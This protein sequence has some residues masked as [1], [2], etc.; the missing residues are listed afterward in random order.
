ML[1]K[2]PKVDG[3]KMRHNSTEHALQAQCLAKVQYLKEQKGE[4]IWATKI[5]S[6]TR[7][8]CPDIILCIKGDFVGVELKRPGSPSRAEGKVSDLQLLNLQ[9]IQR[10]GGFSYVVKYFEDF[11]L[12][13][14]YHLNRPSLSEKETSYLASLSQFTL[15][16]NYA[17]RKAVE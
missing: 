16:N 5:T 3:Q 17:R 13:L 11:E 12:I 9:S 15:M 7:S 14:N 10:A 2:A 4:M 6:A 1:Y 8:G